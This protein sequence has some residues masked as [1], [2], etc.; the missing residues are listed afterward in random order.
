[1]EYTRRRMIKKQAWR[2]DHYT[3]IASPA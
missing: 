1:V 2:I 3:P